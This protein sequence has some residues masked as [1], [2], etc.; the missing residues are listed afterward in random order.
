MLTGANEGREHL[1]EEH[2]QI[3]ELV[4]DDATEAAVEV[5]KKHFDDAVVTLKRRRGAENGATEV[6]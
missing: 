6:G 1:V 4:R 2:R 5:L 3:S